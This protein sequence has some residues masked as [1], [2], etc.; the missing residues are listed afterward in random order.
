MKDSAFNDGRFVTKTTVHR[1]YREITD[2][3]ESYEDIS[4]NMTPQLIIG[5]YGTV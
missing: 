2:L 4:H 5:E 3:V 1:L